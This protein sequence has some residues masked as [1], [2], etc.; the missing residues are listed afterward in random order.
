VDPDLILGSWD[1]SAT[2]VTIH[3]EG[4]V[5]DDTLTVHNAS[6]D[7]PL[8]ELGSVQL[9]RDYAS[10]ANFSGSQM[11]LSGNSITIVLGTPSGMI[12]HDPSAKQ[13]AW[14]TPYG[15]ATESGHPDSDF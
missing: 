6:D 7:S 1:G 3:F 8:T 2:A 4:P 10:S 11:T 15:T 5:G 13:L 14:T 12:R 9:N